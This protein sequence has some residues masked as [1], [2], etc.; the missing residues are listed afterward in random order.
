MHVALDNGLLVPLDKLDLG[1]AGT[2]LVGRSADGRYFLKIGLARHP[3]KA[4]DLVGEAD[5][6][7][8]LNRKG[9]VS[10]PQLIG[11][12]RLPRAEVE[13][14]LAV[15]Q[16]PYPPSPDVDAFPV[17]VLPYLNSDD[18][19]DIHD[20]LFTLIE[21]RRLGWFHGDLRPDNIRFDPADKIC[22]LID[23]DQAE[24]LTEEQ[25]DL[26]LV[27]YLRWADNRVREKYA[28][29]NFRG[30]FHY[31]G[32]VDLEKHIVP[33]LNDGRLDVA[34]TQLYQAQETTLNKSKIYHSFSYADVF[35]SGERDL[36][37]R[38][39]FLDQVSFE[40][41]ESV[42]DVGCNAGL[43]SAYLAERGCQVTGVDIDPYVIRGAR[44]LANIRGDGDRVTFVCAD[45]DKTELLGNYDTI[46]LFSVLHHTQNMVA[47]AARLAHAC[48]RLIIECR[49]QEVGAKPVGDQWVQTNVWRHENLESLQSGLVNLF[50]GF[51]FKRTLGQGDRGR[52]I[53]ELVR[54][55]SQR[56]VLAA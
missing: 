7:A 2:T 15:D 23:Y 14:V 1:G 28:K 37:E 54:S 30:L 38:R 34:K 24:H 39:A 44:M 26:G 55:A 49:L 22:Y 3:D 21:Q 48:K 36:T 8:D 56:G 32:D 53:F 40:T 27:D 31:F 43:L 17:M 42:L 4:N 16:L 9:C 51:V 41:G 46:M 10:C 19:I 45:L 35:A 12:G 47:N 13:K 52:F 6:I 20:L 5:V 25:Q 33:F 11:M 50:P 18:A 29:W